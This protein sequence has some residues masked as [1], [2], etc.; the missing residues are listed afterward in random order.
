MRAASD[1]PLERLPLFGRKRFEVDRSNVG[2]IT[3]WHVLVHRLCRA[4]GG[5]GSLALSF[6]CDP[7]SHK[8]NN[9]DFFHL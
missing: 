6:T 9:N 5:G 3:V 8:M 1:A 2:C 4:T 7:T